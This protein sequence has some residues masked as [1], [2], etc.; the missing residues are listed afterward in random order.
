MNERKYTAKYFRDSM[1]EWKRKKD[2]VIARWLYRPISF[3]ISSI[4][5]NNGI[6]ANTVS[7]L[8]IIVSIAACACFYFDS[9][10]IH[11]TGVLLVNLWSI[12]DCVDGNIARGVKK[13]PFGVFADA[14]ACYLLLAFLYTSI[15]YAIYIN[16]GIWF[17]SGNVWIIILG[18]LTSSADVVMRLIFHK[19][20]EGEIELDKIIKK[21]NN[22]LDNYK[23]HDPSLREQIIEAANIGGYQP[24]CILICFFLNAL[25]VIIIGCFIMEITGL[26]FY[27]YKSIAN[28]IKLSKRY[29]DEYNDNWMNA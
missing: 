28:A 7:Y 3:W 4:C 21:E 24:I 13:Q 20:R 23:P 27:T 6:S 29:E 1:P 8:T 12:C 25:D 26:V 9:Y 10:Y 11:L 17:T 19:Y 15:G 2:P 22:W 16:G 5:A 18:A 14:T